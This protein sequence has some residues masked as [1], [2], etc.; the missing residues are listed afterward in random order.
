MR[1]LLIRRF[2]FDLDLVG[3][4][5][6]QQRLAVTQNFEF[7]PACASVAHAFEQLAP[8]ARLDSV[9]SKRVTPLPKSTEVAVGLEAQAAASM[10]SQAARMN[11]SPVPVHETATRSSASTYQGPT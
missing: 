4:D 7:H 9:V 6:G 8:P 2:D 3:L 5:L 11:C 1:S 10:A